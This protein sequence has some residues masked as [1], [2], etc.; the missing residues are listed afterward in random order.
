MGGQ[1]TEFQVGEKPVLPL[2]NPVPTIWLLNTYRLLFVFA[3]CHVESSEAR[4]VTFVCIDSFFT[5]EIVD[6]AVSVVD[7]RPCISPTHL[8]T[9]DLLKYTQDIEALLLFQWLK[10]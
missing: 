3:P 8:S 5:F 10:Y 4:P 6:Q 1:V 9:F 2:Q 7:L